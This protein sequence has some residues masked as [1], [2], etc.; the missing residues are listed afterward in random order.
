MRDNNDTV[1][2]DG[3]GIRLTEYAVDGVL[4][5]PRFVKIRAQRHAC[6]ADNLLRLPLRY[7]KGIAYDD[8]LDHVFPPPY[9]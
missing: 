8:E 3:Y 7:V 4:P 9:R 6:A 1:T 5:T 2:I